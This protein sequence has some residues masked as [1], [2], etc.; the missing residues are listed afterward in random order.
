MVPVSSGTDAVHCVVPEAAP[1]SPN[2][3]DHFT[4][5]TATLSDAFP[6]ML[7][8]A[9]VADAMVEPGDVIWIEGACVSG[10]PPVVTGGFVMGG[11]VTGGFV[12]GG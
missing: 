3:V 11:F 8:E 10:P 7:I 9:A 12:T 1:E 5:A 2:E 4:I 6:A